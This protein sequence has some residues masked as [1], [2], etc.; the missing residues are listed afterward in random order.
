MNVLLTG[1]T[2]F[3]GSA[4]FDAAQEI[5]LAVV[6][7]V[8]RREVLTKHNL[9][10]KKFTLV[11]TLDGQ[12]DWGSSLLGVDVVIH[13]AARV[14]VMREMVVD[15]LAEYRSINV[16][17]TLNLASQAALAGVKRFIFISSIKVNGEF[18]LPEQPFTPDDEPSPSDFYGLSKAEAESGLRR[19]AIDS[20]MEV[21]I[22]RP[23]L[24]YGPG[25]KG[26]FLRLIRLINCRV[27]LPLGAATANRRSFVAL[28]NLV[29]LILT[30]VHHPN[31]AN[32]ILLVSDGVDLSTVDLIKRIGLALRRPAYLIYVPIYLL[33]LVARMFGKKFILQRFFGSLQL[34]IDRT[35]KLLDWN[36]PISVEEGFRKMI[37]KS[38]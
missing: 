12:T 30:C 37:E 26:N 6:G 23:P 5:G 1:A 13:C 2:G 19:L 8:R 17:G 28:D 9:D 34:D 25:V 18:T 10:S 15:S 14:H 22:I 16:D 24:V 33:K 27:P 31:A 38:F 20:G 3:V 11:P 7:V 35:C 21:V 4:L 36:P 32:Q 29:D